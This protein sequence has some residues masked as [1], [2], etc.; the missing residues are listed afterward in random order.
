VTPGVRSD[1]NTTCG[2]TS[3]AAGS[4]TV[5]V[6]STLAQLQPNGAPDGRFAPGGRIGIAKP[7][8][9]SINAVARSGSRLVVLAGSAGNAVYVA[10]Y[11]LPNG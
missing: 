7:R 5:G 11:L 2:A 4:L 8:Q 10:R 9:V 6:G 3:T 1:A